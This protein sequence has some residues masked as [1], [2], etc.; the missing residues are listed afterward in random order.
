MT[1][2]LGMDFDQDGFRFQEDDDVDN[3]GFLNEDDKCIHP[4]GLEVDTEGC[5]GVQLDDDGDGVHNLN[6]LCPATPPGDALLQDAIRL[7]IKGNLVKI[8]KRLRF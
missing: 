8:M 3:D 5:S 2:G 1:A 7:P 6:D 4:L